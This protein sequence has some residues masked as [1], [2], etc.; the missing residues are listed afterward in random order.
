MIAGWFDSR[1]RP[2][3]RTRL[4]IPRLGVVGHV[5]FLV[6]T[7]AT[8]TSLHPD[9]G[10]RIHCP[11]DELRD[12]SSFAGVGG[13]HSY[14]REPAVVVLYDSDGARTFDIILSISRPQL[15]SASEPRPIVN[16]LPSL[17]G[18]D[19]LNRLRMDYDFPAGR[20]QFFA[21]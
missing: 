19:V 16:R 9:D 4:V 1:G 6:D 8:A 13:S 21:G 3:V 5:N 2:L 10:Q 20:L 12:L 18:R 14:Y 7:G 17:L 15:P 11:F